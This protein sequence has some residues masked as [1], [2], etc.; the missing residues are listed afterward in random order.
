MMLRRILALSLLSM[1]SACQAAPLSSLP[2]PMAAFAPQRPLNA[3]NTPRSD[4][5]ASLPPNL[6]N[7]YAEA[8]GQTG[9]ALFESLSKIVSRSHTN[10]LGYGEARNFM[11]STADN[12][13][14]QN[15]SGL[16]GVYSDVFIPGTSPSGNDYRERGD[17]NRDGTSGDFINCEHTWPQSFFNKSAPMVSDMHHL[18]PTLSKPNGMRG[19]H[20][21]GEA[22]EGRISYS[23]SSGSRLVIRSNRVKAAKAPVDAEEGL[24]AFSNADAVFEPGDRQKGN[25]AR[26]MMYF[27]L[28]YR[29]GK[30]R[31]GDFD[32]QA[33]WASRVP[34]FRAWAEQV[35]PVDE[36][37]RIRHDHIAQKQGNR[38]P[39]ID[40]PNLIALIGED[41]ISRP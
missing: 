7:Y 14:T 25:T 29:N 26:A 2:R 31:S 5:F 39:F 27:W 6:Q 16:L 8:R 4:W 40:I 18:F 33:F 38:N 36:R 41:V 1:L 9:A 35:D 10:S 19:H 12:F 21:F 28:R 3:L 17:Q 20:P 37:E 15:Q 32:H 23:T 34:M 24:N 11:Y 22:R 13:K 30:I